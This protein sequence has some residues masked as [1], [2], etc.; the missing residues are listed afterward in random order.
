RQHWHYGT[1]KYEAL[2]VYH[3][4]LEASGHKIVVFDVS[5]IINLESSLRISRPFLTIAGQTSPGGILVTG[6]QTT[7]QAHDVIMRHMRYRVGSHRI[8][9]GADPEKL[10]SFDILGI[11]WNGNDDVYNVIIDHSSFSWGVDETFTVSGGVNSTTIQWSIISEGLSHAGHPKGEH[12]KG[13]MVSGKCQTACPGTT[14]SLHH[15]YIAHNNARSPLISSP[16]DVDITANAVNNVIY[17]WNGGSSPQSEGSTKINWEHNYSKQ[18]VNSNDYSFEV[19]HSIPFL[20]AVPQIYVFGNIGSTRLSQS[21]PQWNVGTHWRN[22]L[23][24]ESFRKSTP[25]NTPAITTTPMSD[26]YALEVLATVGATKPFRD[27][28]DSRV[29]EEFSYGTGSIIDDIKFPEDFPVFASPIPPIDN[30]NDGMADAWERDNNLDTSI[31]DSANITAD[32]YTNIEKY[33]HQLAGNIVATEPTE[34]DLMVD[35][36]ATNGKFDKETETIS[37][38]VGVSNI[39]SNTAFNTTL[40][41]T[42]PSEVTISSLITEQGICD[43]TSLICNL[44]AIAANQT[45]FV[46]VVVSTTNNKKMA[47]SATIT[48]N[49]TDSD[50]AN[51]QSTK[52]F[53]GS[54]GFW[55]LSM[56]ALFIWV[57]NKKMA[58]PILQGKPSKVLD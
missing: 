23:L 51:N 4:R 19:Q 8:T 57:R 49:T 7:I 17:N 33:L 28:V 5:G 53:G 48:S 6:Y 45:I 43:D 2:D 42:L 24:D 31:D 10:D 11:G 22:I 35:L 47:F 27:S 30:D 13:L 20:P 25:W 44:G 26:T 1:Y 56:F 41:H 14:I 21:E 34:S 38:Q 3:A 12:S 50:L 58:M 40:T 39:S 55:A 29:I 9:N 54:I 32:G 37:Y 16:E 46:E 52:R 18:G 36:T 15:N